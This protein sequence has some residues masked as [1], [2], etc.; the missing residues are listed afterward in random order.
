MTDNV[1]SDRPISKTTIDIILI[2]V[3]FIFFAI[4]FIQSM[5]LSET[6]GLVPKLT[7][8][9]ALVLCIIQ[10]VNDVRKRNAEQLSQKVEVIEQ[11]KLKW[12]YMLLI[13]VSYVVSLYLLGFVISAFSFLC[14]TPYIMK[15]KKIKANLI[16][17]SAA[18]IVL[19]YAF[20]QIF[21]VQ[22]PSGLL[23]DYL[24]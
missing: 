11:A 2:S 8:G 19:Y 18:T 21:F 24:F 9:V 20:V 23:I 10:I 22:L 17:A 13:L 6:A 14:I 1:K 15:H 12:Y 4:V 3:M 5:L 7:S 16:L